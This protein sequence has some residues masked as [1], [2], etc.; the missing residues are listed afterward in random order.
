MSLRSPFRHRRF[1]D[2]ERRFF[3]AYCRG[4]DHDPRELVVPMGFFTH[5]DVARAIRA[6]ECGRELDERAL[7][8][9]WSRLYPDSEPSRFYRN[10]A[11]FAGLL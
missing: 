5:P 7:G 9:A 8:A 1:L 2:A 10:L 11:H 3:D 6:W 4:G